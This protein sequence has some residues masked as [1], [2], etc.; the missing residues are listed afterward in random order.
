MAEQD[1]ARIAQT[2]ERDGFAV[3]RDFIPHQS[4]EHAKRL[5][6]DAVA[7]SGNE[8]VNKIMNLDEFDD[9]F[10]HALVH[11]ESFIGLCRRICSESFTVPG[12]ATGLVPSLRCLAGKSGIQQSMFFHYDSYVLAAL[13]PII[14]P[15]EGARGRLI[16]HPNR[17]RVRRTYLVNVLDKLFVD[18]R[19]SQR[20]YQEMY[21]RGSSELR[22]I[23][24]VPGNLYL[25]WGYRSVHTNEAC[26]PDKIRST[27]IFHYGDP[28]AGSG[29]KRL[30]KA[31]GGVRQRLAS[32]AA[33]DQPAT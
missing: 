20:S 7:S 25:F 4:I 32:W 15:G 22:Y 33:R 10:L 19:A 30:L 5:I 6:E 23:D 1:P 8:S 11:D 13:I 24:V 26:D 16:V 12:P 21:R 29:M 2:I 3:L 28:H 27:A 14:I 18:S 31:R 9:T 17:R